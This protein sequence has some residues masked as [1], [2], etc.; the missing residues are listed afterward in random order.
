MDLLPVDG[1]A[2]ELP[3]NDGFGLIPIDNRLAQG[4]MPHQGVQNPVLQPAPPQNHAGQQGQAYGSQI[5]GETAHNPFEEQFVQGPVNQQAAGA[6]AQHPYN[7]ISQP[8]TQGA[9]NNQ[10]SYLPMGQQAGQHPNTSTQQAAPQ[11]PPPMNYQAAQNP[12]V[13]QYV[14]APTETIVQMDTI[15]ARVVGTPTHEAYL[16]IAGTYEGKDTVRLS[17]KVEC[18]RMLTRPP[19][20]RRYLLLRPQPSLQPYSQHVRHPSFS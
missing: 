5:A 2:P 20:S 19:L 6:G 15:M 8:F 9:M 7:P 17:K 11:A 3:P 14:G 13:Y 1:E 16:A 10:V 12:M 4:P 18:I